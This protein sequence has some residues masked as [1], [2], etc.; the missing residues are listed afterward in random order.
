MT[1][2]SDERIAKL[3]TQ[4]QYMS[5]EIA[6]MRDDI[7]DIKRDVKELA[8]NERKR[9]SFVFGVVFAVSTL[10]AFVGGVLAFFRHKFGG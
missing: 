1:T 7:R 9:N 2:P 5:R 4:K 3:E 8:D 10:W 6:E